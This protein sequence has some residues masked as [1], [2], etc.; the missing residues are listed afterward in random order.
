[1]NRENDIQR[2]VALFVRKL[3]HST[4]PATPLQELKL[5]SCNKNQI[6]NIIANKLFSTIK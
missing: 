3:E 4:N 1:M 6:D 5:K 2:E